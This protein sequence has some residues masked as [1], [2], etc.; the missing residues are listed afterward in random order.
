MKVREL[1]DGSPG[2]LIAADAVRVDHEGNVWVDLEA[3]VEL[4]ADPEAD[5]LL[6]LGVKRL[7]E[8][9]AEELAGRELAPPST[10][11]RGEMGRVTLW[12]RW[13]YSWT[14]KKLPAVM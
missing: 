11:R 5:L 8:V 1:P 2:G 3:S 10:P 4:Q 14:L 6:K 12:R 13:S 9:P 7:I